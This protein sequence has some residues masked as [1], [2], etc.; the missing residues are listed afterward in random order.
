MW[1]VTWAARSR[2]RR[3]TE[4]AP[5]LWINR[6]PN[7]WVLS[8]RWY[9]NFIFTDVHMRNNYRPNWLKLTSFLLFPYN[10]HSA[11]WAWLRPG[12]VQKTQLP[13]LLS[14]I[15]SLSLTPQGKLAGWGHWP[16]SFQTI[17]NTQPTLP[18][19]SQ[20]IWISCDYCNRSYK[21][22]RLW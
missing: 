15:I 2:V 21:N 5:P 9:V 7:P 14:L 22:S 16:C 17:G 1:L 6:H 10:P 20:L 3:I 8:L 13:W 12:F 19:L 11:S 4:L 18:R